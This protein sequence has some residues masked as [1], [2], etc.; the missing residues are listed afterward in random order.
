M[1]AAGFP[2][3]DRRR[4][5]AHRRQPRRAQ[6][7][8]RGRRAAGLR[9]DPQHDRGH[10]AP[11]GR[12]SRRSCSAGRSG[13]GRAATQGAAAGRSP[14]IADAGSARRWPTS[15]C[16]RRSATGSAAG[17]ASS[18]P[19]SRAAVGRDRRV[20]RRR[21]HDDPRGLRPHR[22]LRRE[23]REP[24]GRPALRDGRPADARHRGEDRRGRRGAVPEPRHHARLPRPAG[25]DRG[26]LLEGGW[27]ATGDIGELDEAGRLRI[28]DR[29][30][31]LIKTSGG[32]YVAPGAD[33]EPDQGDVPLRRQRRRA[34]RQAQLLRRA[35]DARPGRDEAVGKSEGLSE[36]MA[37]L[38]D[39]QR[40]RA[41]VPPGDRPGQREPAE[42]LHDQGV[43][44]PAGGLH[45]G[46]RRADAR[47]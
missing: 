44:D 31:E 24:A 2:T 6:A 16:C 25:G 11:R 35:G 4:R 32:K 36:D 13:V 47:A 21:G 40:M 12:R 1:I 38:A 45:R 30:K 29:K 33:R 22:V 27:L 3:A 19:G 28:T 23:L 17:S 7:H 42:L 20:L 34:R 9:E 37:V 39:D 26:T 41:E 46:D 10:R 8:D 43:R 5:R 15:W 14:S 18:S